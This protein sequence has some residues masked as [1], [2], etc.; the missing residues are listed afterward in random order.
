MSFD[1]DLRDPYIGLISL[2]YYCSYYLL[3][4]I[5]IKTINIKIYA[6]IPVVLTRVIFRQRHKKAPYCSR[7]L[8]NIGS[9]RKE[10][11]FGIISFIFKNNEFIIAPIFHSRNVDS[12]SIY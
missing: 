7:L 11:F 10:L 4:F 3:I 1:T 2:V 8:E 9:K 6:N 12:N 5:N